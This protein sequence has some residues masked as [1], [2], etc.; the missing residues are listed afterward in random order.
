[1]Y[2]PEAHL[3]SAVHLIHRSTP[4]DYC[5]RLCDN[6]EYL[7]AEE[8]SIPKIRE[9]WH[10]WW[11]PYGEAMLA[12]HVTVVSPSSLPWNTPSTWGSKPTHKHL[13]QA[14]IYNWLDQANMYH[15]LMETGNFI[16]ATACKLLG[17]CSH[18]SS[19]Y[20]I[21]ATV[22][23]LTCPKQSLDCPLACPSANPLACPSACPL[24]YHVSQMPS[25]HDNC[26]L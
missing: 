19:H 16:Y 23:A 10:M 21:L 15:V 20:H 7:L 26:G 22:S 4:G 14:V 12:E 24:A 17:A 1:M 11:H 5:R 9:G 13:D 6:A 18:A 8:I 2:S 3:D 25:M